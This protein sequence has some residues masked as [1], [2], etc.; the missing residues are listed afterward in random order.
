LIESLLAGLP[1]SA[2]PLAYLGLLLIGAKLGEE[3][4]RRLGLIPFVGAIFVGTLLGPG[5][6]GFISVVPSTSLFIGLGINFLLFVSGAVEFESTRFRS[7]L[8]SKTTVPLAVL[9]FTTRFL[10][11]TVIAF[12]LFHQP[13]TAIVIG[14]VAGMS[15]AGPLSRLLT[16][17]GLAKTDEGTAIFSQVV[18]IEIAAV[19]LFSFV[20]DLAGKAITAFSIASVALEVSLTIIGIILFGRYVFVPLLEKVETHFHGREAVFAI[21]IAFILLLGFL[22]E[23]TGFNSAI[24]AL[25]LGL[26]LQNFFAARPVLLEKVNAFTY[27][28]FEPLFFVGLGLYFV[29]VTPYLLLAGLAIFGMALGLD[30]IVGAV[31]SRAFKV[32]M[33]RNAFGT[34]VNGG[35]DAALLVTALTAGTVLIGGFSYSAAAIG[36][37]LLSLVAPLLFRLR[38]PLVEIDKESGT[39]KIVKQQLDTLTAGEICKTLPTVSTHDTDPVKKG[40]KQC[41]DLD[42]RA[43][44]VLN[45]ENEPVATLLLRDVLTMTNRE[46]SRLK[47]IEAPLAEA[48]IVT[49]SEPALK[50]ASIFKETNIPIVAVV[51]KDD[52]LIGT[53]LE[54]EILRRMMTSLEE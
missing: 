11:I 32:G 42:A 33:W 17:T 10:G 21:I 34:C 14:I 2:L 40:M 38:A 7:M 5:V 23:I 16:D 54:R 6:L 48:I 47:V 24:V 19:V 52:K 25:F 41:L 4:F 51:D 27:G 36:I 9:Q 46:M 50:L 29:R 15:S 37:A 31:T 13:L 1:A 12:L 8:R 43:A 45:S 3:G 28:F 53:I 39:R 44:V 18:I 49:E 30:G 26:L 35:V 22:G 20:Y